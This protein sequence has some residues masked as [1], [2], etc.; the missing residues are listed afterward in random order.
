M[1]KMTDAY[2][3]AVRFTN[4]ECGDADFSD[5]DFSPLALSQAFRDCRDLMWA[6]SDLIRK[7]NETQA[8]YDLWLTR[9]CHGSGFWD[10]PE[11][12]GKVGSDILTRCA[13]SM[14]PRDVY[15]GDDGL[16]Y[17]T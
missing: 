10:K 7:E 8:G 1:N 17:F 3:E 16:L 15:I 5:A 12:W 9:N 13:H 11:V 6:N 14:G 2:L 4:E